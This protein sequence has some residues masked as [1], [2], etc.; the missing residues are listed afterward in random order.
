MQVQGI[1]TLA[2][3]VDLMRDDSHE[4]ACLFRDLLIGV[5]QFFR[6]P[7]SFAAVSNDPIEKIFENKTL[8]DEIRV[9][10]PGCA[11]DRRGTSATREKFLPVG[12]S[13]SGFPRLPE[14]HPAGELLTAHRYL[15]SHGSRRPLRRRMHRVSVDNAKAAR[16][17]RLPPPKRQRRLAGCV[18]PSVSD[19]FDRL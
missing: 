4:P 12:F 3:Y 8:D 18:I 16:D 13:L 5:T 19:I 2:G 10:V 9:W 14:R 15:S 7:E 6:D 1:D 17:V 11:T